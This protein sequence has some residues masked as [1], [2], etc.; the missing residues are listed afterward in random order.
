M[1]IHVMRQRVAEISPEA[2]FCDGFDEAL[3]GVAT[4]YGMA[5]VAAY[6]FDKMIEIIMKEGCDYE[7]AVEHFKFNIRGAWVGECTPIFVHRLS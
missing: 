3:I 2:L 6:D 1:Q 7:Q 5:P 4:R